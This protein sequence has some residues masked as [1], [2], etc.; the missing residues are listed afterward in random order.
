MATIKSYTDLEQSKKLAEI[1]P[2]ESADMG[3][4]W[5]GISFSEVPAS[6][7]TIF[8]RIENIPCWSLTSLLDVIKEQGNVDLR[9]LQSTFDNRGNHLTKVWCCSFEDI[10]TVSLDLYA[11]NPVDACYEMVLKLHELK[12]L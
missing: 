8:K 1:L 11:N 7:Q 6:N 12:M 5:N 4:L 3:Y 9:F 10:G 2:L